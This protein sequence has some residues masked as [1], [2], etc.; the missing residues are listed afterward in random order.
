MT[1]HIG[2]PARTNSSRSGPPHEAA[3]TL[4]PVVGQ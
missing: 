2:T 3:R 1:V 4:C